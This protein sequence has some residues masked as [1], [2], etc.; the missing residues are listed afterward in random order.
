MVIFLQFLKELN[1]DVTNDITEL[2]T[3][4]SKQNFEIK[5]IHKLI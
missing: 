5:W 1:K 4:Q 3:N 2:F